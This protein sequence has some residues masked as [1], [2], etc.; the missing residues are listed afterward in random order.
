MLTCSIVDVIDVVVAV[1]VALVVADI[2]PI[3][4][5]ARK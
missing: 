5:R 2:F 1:A 4:I 3:L